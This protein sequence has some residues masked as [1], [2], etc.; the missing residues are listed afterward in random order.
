MPSPF[1]VPLTESVQILKRVLPLMSRQRVPTIPQNYA[2]WYDFVAERNEA[3]AIELQGL[4]DMGGGFSP[5]LCRRIYEKYYLDEIRNEVGGIQEAVREAVEAVLS[6]LGHL[7]NDI[8]RF[9]EV[10]D[11]SDRT[12]EDNPTVGVVREIVGEL[13]R[14]TRIAKERSAEVE[15]TLS[16]M[17]SELHQVRSQ[18]IALSRDSRTDSLTGVANRRSFDE[19]LKRRIEEATAD[20]SSLCLAMADVDHFK[21]FND[22][23]GHLVGDIVLRFVAQEIEQC[24][25]G[26]DLLARYGGEEFAILLPATPLVGAM[27]LAESIRALIEVQVLQ[28]LRG[29]EIDR[30]TLSLGIA[31][32]IPGETATAFIQRAD[33]CLY[34]SKENGRNRVTSETELVSH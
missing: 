26:Q 10:L 2:I 23:H 16:T 31:E 12:L 1:E 29:E 9:S 15:S 13:V 7:G 3:L 30:V 20:G 21:A 22:V 32:Y 28:N 27:M 8:N 5:E 25:K 33:A 18:V 17:A 19:T 34:R 6:E 11:K 14:E 24:V 4:I